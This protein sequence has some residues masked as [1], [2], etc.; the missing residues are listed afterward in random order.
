MR[1]KIFLKTLKLIIN[2]WG[3]CREKGGGAYEMENLRTK[4]HRTFVYL[5]FS[6]P[7]GISPV[8]QFMQAII[9]FLVLYGISWGN[10]IT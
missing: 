10:T 2:G 9:L 1:G 5:L 6:G 8:V 4:C 3:K 7:P